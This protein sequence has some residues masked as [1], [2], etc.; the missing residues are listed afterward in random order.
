MLVQH[1]LPEVIQVLGWESEFDLE[2]VLVLAG[3][4]LKLKEMGLVMQLHLE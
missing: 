2:L 4:F 1:N 3:E